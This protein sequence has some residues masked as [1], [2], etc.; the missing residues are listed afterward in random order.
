MTKLHPRRRLATLVAATSLAVG[1][2]CAAAPARSEPAE[3]TEAAT[4]GRPTI[5]LV[6][7]AFAESASWES[8]IKRL[9]A[10]GYPVVAAANP[11]RG[12]H[13]DAVYLTNL[14]DNIPGPVVLVGHSYGGSVITNAATGRANVKA[15]VYVAA[16]A[17]DAGESAATLSAKYPGSTLGSA[18]LPPVQLS[19]GNSDLYVKPSAYRQSFAAD[20]PPRSAELLA[21]TQRP[22]AQAALVEPSGPPAWNVIPSWFIYGTRDKAIPPALQP[23]M[24]RRAHSRHTVA[25]DGAS[26]AVMASHP[27]PVAELIMEAAGAGS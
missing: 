12:V 23:F 25:V 1:L 21:A 7:G 9:L 15:L 10:K 19:D 26:H 16:F 22:L 3:A 8:V 24:A 17:P 6:H 2:A 4:G 5:V 27:A 13:S 11:L 18:L 14:L 20:V